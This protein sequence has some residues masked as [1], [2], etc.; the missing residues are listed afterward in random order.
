MQAAISALHA[1]AGRAEETGWRQIAGLYAVLLA[2][3]SSPIVEL[4]RAVAVAQAYGP[5]EGLRL[6]DALES[7]RDLSGYHLL[8]S[9]RGQLLLR[10]GRFSEAAQTYAR[11]LSL[12]TNPAERRFLSRRL[13][14][15]QRRR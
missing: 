11:A 1:Q 2:I 3:A 12:A 6:Q 13:E 7:R 10:L 4:N 5:A 8:A 9:A 14:E 15:T